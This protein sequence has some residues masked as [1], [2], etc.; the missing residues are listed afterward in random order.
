VVF[1]VAGVCG[2]GALA[3]AKTEGVFGVGVDA[4]YG[5][6]GP[7]ILTS[8]IK[9]YDV[10]LL[11]ELRAFENGTLPADGTSSFGLRERAV[12]LGK[13]SPRVPK[14]QLRQL[15][16]VRSQIVAGKIRVPTRLR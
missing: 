9:N 1:D 7:H 5:S 6:L 2:E 15:D 14:A 16:V 10:A 8:A 12:G 11:R 3:A 13:V 4:D